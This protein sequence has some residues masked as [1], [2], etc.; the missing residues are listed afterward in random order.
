M[1]PLI[2]EHEYIINKIKENSDGLGA[3]T[4]RKIITQNQCNV[5]QKDHALS[6]GI[7]LWNLHWNL[8]GHG[9]Y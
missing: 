5:K 7:H 9:L 3:Q 6:S 4:K 2:L 8:H 1:H